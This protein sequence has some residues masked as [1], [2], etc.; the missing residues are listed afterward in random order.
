EVAKVL[1]IREATVVRVVAEYNKGNSE[2]PSP[3]K[4]QARPKKSWIVILLDFCAV[5]SWLQIPP[6]PIIHTSVTSKA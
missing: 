5:L 2:E 3:S 6:V 4:I 1:E